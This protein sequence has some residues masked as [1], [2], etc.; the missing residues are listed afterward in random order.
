MR[1]S[2]EDNEIERSKAYDAYKEFKKHA[3]KERQSWLHELAQARATVK[4]K[5]AESRPTMHRRKKKLGDNALPPKSNSSSKQNEVA[6]L[7]E[8]FA[9]PPE[10]LVSLASPL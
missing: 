4:M 3:W 7:L 6:I 2:V 5:K 9:M 10:L 8:E 1:Q